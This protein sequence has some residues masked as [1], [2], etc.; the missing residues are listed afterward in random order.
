MMSGWPQL[1]PLNG[2]SF[3]SAAPVLGHQT[4][5]GAAISAEE[6]QLTDKGSQRS[7][8]V[9]AGR[10]FYPQGQRSGVITETCYNYLK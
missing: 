4:A 9:K 5:D 1:T 2:F 3:Y 7:L 6:Q 10:S 8:D